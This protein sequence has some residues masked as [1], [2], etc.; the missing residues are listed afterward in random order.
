MT[1]RI[2]VFILFFAFFYDLKISE[3]ILTV[4]FFMGAI[5]FVLFLIEMMANRVTFK[6]RY[7]SIIFVYSL[8]LL[9]NYFTCIINNSNE[10]QSLYELK[11]LL[12]IFFAAFFLVKVSSRYITSVSQ[13]FD[14]IILLA[15]VQC[16]IAVVSQFSDSVHAFVLANANALEE[17]LEHEQETRLIGIGS[18]VFFGVLPTSSLASL[19]CVYQ[20]FHSPMKRKTI[21][22]I[23]FIIISFITFLM[24]RTSLFALISAIVLYI[25]YSRESGRSIRKSKKINIS[26]L[27]VLPIVVFIIFRL[28]ETY[29]SEQMFEW[30]FNSFSRDSQ[31]S[32]VREIYDWYAFTTIDTETFWIGDARLTDNDGYYMGLDAGYLR[33]IFY[34]GLIGLLLYFFYQYYIAR[35]IFKA[36]NNKDLW[37]FV[38]AYFLFYFFIMIKGYTSIAKELLFLLV[39]IDYGKLKINENRVLS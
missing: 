5:G 14:I 26:L 6:K 7:L 31:N 11:F 17:F 24:A 38:L 23:L 2:I 36:T 33:A 20:F 12:I 13:L 8:L 34:F 29:M 10:F 25:Y 22:A 35:I 28:V 16:S 30:A 3:P 4:R 9:W 1:G 15:L 37:L 21:Y 19:A 39:M 27:I 18:A 32:T